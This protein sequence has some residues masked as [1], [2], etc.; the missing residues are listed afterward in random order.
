MVSTIPPLLRQ[1][2][3][4]KQINLD[5]G[6]DREREDDAKSG[7]AATLQIPGRFKFTDLR[8]SRNSRQSGEEIG[9][10]NFYG[11]LRR[12]GTLW[13][14][15]K[16]FLLFC[17]YYHKNSRLL[18]SFVACFCREGRNYAECFWHFWTVL[19]EWN[20]GRKNAEMAPQVID[21]LLRLFC[22]SVICILL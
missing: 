6:M 12:R 21:V 15:R 16:P 18:S 7:D 1:T 3:G 19:H 13:P 9:L 20:G 14:S 22:I 17:L 5:P 2:T 10:P 4:C 11:P 8:S